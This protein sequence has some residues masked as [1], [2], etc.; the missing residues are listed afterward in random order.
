MSD[1][2]KMLYRDGSAT[3]WE[4]KTFDT[5]I[6]DDKD[7][8]KE[9]LGDGWR[10]AADAFEAEV[11]DTDIASAIAMLDPGNDDHWTNAGLP[12]VDAV[13]ELVGETVTRAQIKAVAPDAERP[14]Q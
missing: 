11:A 14:E 2:P 9:A 3:E 13:S 5:L 7:E 10:L 12:A 1:Y 8:E 6:V 4:G